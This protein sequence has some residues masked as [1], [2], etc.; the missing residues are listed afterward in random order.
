MNQWLALLPHE[1]KALP[2]AFW[3]ES[4]AEAEAICEEFGL[5]LEGVAL[6]IPPEIEIE[7]DEDADAYCRLLT[8]AAS[9]VKN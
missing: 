7:S 4:K 2:I 9:A 8:E 1:H 5:I 3:A 6:E